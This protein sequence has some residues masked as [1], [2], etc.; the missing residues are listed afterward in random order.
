V[1][2]TVS[3]PSR[4]RLAF[5]AVAAVLAGA[6]SAAEGPLVYVSGYGPD[7]ICYSL[8]AAAGA[9]S[10]ISRSPGGTNPSFLAWSPSRANLYA[11]NEGGALGKVVSFAIAP[12]DGALKR[13]GEGSSGGSGPC[14]VSVHPGGKWVYAA[15]YGSGHVAVLPVGADGGLSDPIDVQLAGKNAHMAIT[16]KAGKFLFVPCLGSDHIAVYRIDATSGK[17]SPNSQATVPLAKG[18]GPRHLAFAPDERRAYVINELNATLTSFA[19]DAATGVFSAPATV[20]TLPAGFSGKN[21]CAHVVV[22]PDGASLYGSNR[23]HD[24]LVICRIDPASGALTVA[25]HETGG[26]EIKTPRNFTLDPSGTLAL[27]ASQGSDL[28]TVFRVDAATGKLKRLGSQ[29]V[30]PKPS[31]VGVMPRP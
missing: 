14:H 4:L 23:G 13:L 19:F 5:T 20:S 26:G 27:V 15:N 12:A 1:R 6:A 9:L 8:D 28:V 30:G 31:F 21:S 29:K 11:C 22:S 3:R 18:A 17:L 10:E 2:P 25:G 16:D 24:S 7:I